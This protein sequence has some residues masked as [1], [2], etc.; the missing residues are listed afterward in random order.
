MNA[1]GF[2]P[3]IRLLLEGVAS[4]ILVQALAKRWWETTHSFH[5]I[6]RE[7][8]VTPHNFHQMTDLRSHK[9]T[10]NLEGK[11]GIQL[12]IDLLGRAILVSTF[13]TLIWRGTTSLFLR[14]LQM[15][16]LRWAGHFYYMW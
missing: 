14:Q 11:S 13:A 9:P 5:I 8:T 2:G 7:I 10:I 15:I 3:L 16:V 6:E 1:A 12:G 4:G